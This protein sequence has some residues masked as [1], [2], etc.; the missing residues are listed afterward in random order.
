M[1]QTPTAAPPTST[2]RPTTAPLAS[3]AVPPPL[4]SCEPARRPSSVPGRRGGPGHVGQQ[5]GHRRAGEP[6]GAVR[7]GVD[8]AEDGVRARP[9]GGASAAGVQP[10][11][12]RRPTPRRSGAA[13]GAPGA[14]S[15]LAAATPRSRS[16]TVISAG[17]SRAK[18]TWKSTRARSWAAGVGAGRG[19]PLG[20]AGEQPL[21]DPHQHLGEHRVLAGEVPVDRRAGDADGRADVVH[22]RPRGS[23]ARRTAGRPRAGSAPGGR[24]SP[25]RCAARCPA[26]GR[27]A[28]RG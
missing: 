27:H 4:S 19:D 28:P 10:G 15:A 21:A 6:P 3:P 26:V 18:S 24:G 5:R 14:A 12:G 20:A 13:A 8:Q 25:R 7:G 1:D 2:G 17:L 22:A 11:R 9:A 16:C 23:R